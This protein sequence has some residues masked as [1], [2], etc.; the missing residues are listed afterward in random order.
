MSVFPNVGGQS[1]SGH[2]AP[3]NTRCPAAN[4]AARQLWIAG[5]TEAFAAEVHTPTP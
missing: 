3:G 1:V 5:Q 2:G 4:D